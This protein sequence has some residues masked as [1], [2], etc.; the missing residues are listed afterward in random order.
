MTVPTHTS[1]QLEERHSSLCP[2]MP[3][4]GLCENHPGPRLLRSWTFVRLK[5]AT[6]EAVEALMATGFAKV[7]AAAD[8]ALQATARATGGED[9]QT[10]A[11]H[12]LAAWIA[13][14]GALRRALEEVAERCETLWGLP[15]GAASAEA[16]RSGA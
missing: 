3:S 2:W 14:G 15:R 11:Q 9:A 1:A 5:A 4:P 12:E 10:P 7:I 16:G 6:P 8:E 13:D